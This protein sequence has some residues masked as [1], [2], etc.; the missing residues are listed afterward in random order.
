MK[1]HP[2]G[3]SQRCMVLAPSLY[4]YV[5]SRVLRSVRLALHPEFLSFRVL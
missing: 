5:L 1:T 3:A 4:N 2:S